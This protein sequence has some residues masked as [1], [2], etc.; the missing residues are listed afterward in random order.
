MKKLYISYFDNND[1]QR[2]ATCKTSAIEAVLDMG[3]YDV[4]ILESYDCA[5]TVIE[6]TDTGDFVSSHT[7]DLSEDA[8]AYASAM[9]HSIAAEMK[10]NS[11]LPCLR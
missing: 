4:E 1:S 5:T 10:D 3:G 8:E 7:I 2:I 11:D 6:L 9:N